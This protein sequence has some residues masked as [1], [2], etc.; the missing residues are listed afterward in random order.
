MAMTLKETYSQLLVDDIIFGQQYPQG[1][2]RSMQSSTQSRVQGRGGF[3]RNLEHDGEVKAGSGTGG[4]LDPNCASHE[5]DQ[6]G[7]DC[8]SQSSTAEPPGGGSIS[9]VECLEYGLLLLGRNA[10]PRIGDTDLKGYCTAR[11]F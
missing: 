7:G 4:A 1:R 2:Q 8:Q 3:N 6:V 9:L 10:D 11:R 5:G